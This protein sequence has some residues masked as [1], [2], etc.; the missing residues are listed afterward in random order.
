ML[1]RS[2]V[3]LAMLTVMVA[4]ERPAVAARA[5]HPAGTAAARISADSPWRDAT[6]TPSP[7]PSLDEPTPEPSEGAPAGPVPPAPPPKPVACTASASGSLTVGPIRTG[8]GSTTLWYSVNAGC[9]VTA[10]LT[11]NFGL[12]WSATCN[13]FPCAGIVGDQPPPAAAPTGVTYSLSVTDS[14]GQSRTVASARGS[15]FA[16]PTPIPLPGSPSPKAM[17]RDPGL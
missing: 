9:P 6:P 4:C 3:L 5:V 2:F 11:S 8:T 14:T 10:L 12:R 16:T 17:G 1:G 13:W 15:S 7:A